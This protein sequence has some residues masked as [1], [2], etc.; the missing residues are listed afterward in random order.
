MSIVSLNVLE[1]V[2]GADILLIKI[3]DGFSCVGRGLM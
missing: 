3:L 1:V 2:P